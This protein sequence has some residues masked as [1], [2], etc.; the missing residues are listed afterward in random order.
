[1]TKIRLLKIIDKIIGRLEELEPPQ[2]LIDDVLSLRSLVEKGNLK[3]SGAVP[4]R[5]WDASSSKYVPVKRKEN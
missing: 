4:G 3:K 5:D 1:M 2:D